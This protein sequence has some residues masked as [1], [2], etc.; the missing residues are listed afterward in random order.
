MTTDQEK[1]Q[2]QPPPHSFWGKGEKPS[3][4]VKLA[5]ITVREWRLVI[6]LLTTFFI[7]AM[8]GGVALIYTVKTATINEMDRDL[9]LSG[10]VS[11]QSI[12]NQGGFVYEGKVYAVAESSI[13]TTPEKIQKSLEE[14]IDMNEDLRKDVQHL[15][16][17]LE[18]ERSMNKPITIPSPNNQ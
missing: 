12:I 7:M 6:W 9:L 4:T 18:Y 10:Y 2:F 8:L 11:A 5:D 14:A 13:M 17:K 1:E 3:L 15:K 16:D